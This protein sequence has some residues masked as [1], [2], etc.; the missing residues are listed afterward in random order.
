MNTVG[1]EEILFDCA[2]RCLNGERSHRCISNFV[3]GY[4]MKTV[5]CSDRATSFVVAAGSNDLFAQLP[6]TMRN[7][8]I[9]I[10]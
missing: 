10:Q 9:I 7:I 4:N 5:L 6:W 1:T 2:A 8:V 3:I